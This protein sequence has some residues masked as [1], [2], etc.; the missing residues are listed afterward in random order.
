MGVS[1]NIL[2]R[3]SKRLEQVFRTPFQTARQISIGFHLAAQRPYWGM[4]SLDLNLIFEEE[5]EGRVFEHAHWMQ[6]MD[7]DWFSTPLTHA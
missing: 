6:Q 7:W 2:S 4:D 5:E 1:P 3:S